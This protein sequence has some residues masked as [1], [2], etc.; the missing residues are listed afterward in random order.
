MET[1]SVERAPKRTIWQKFGP[2]GMVLALVGILILGTA[3]FASWNSGTGIWDSGASVAKARAG[4]AE[5][6]PGSELDLALPDVS[7]SH[8]SSELRPTVAPHPM[9][10]ER[11]EPLCPPHSA[12]CVSMTSGSPAK[13]LGKLAAALPSGAAKRYRIRLEIIPLEDGE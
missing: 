5:P 11:E 1:N 9:P 3:L 7:V 2:R 8:R 12:F 10:V 13:T 4:I 6:C